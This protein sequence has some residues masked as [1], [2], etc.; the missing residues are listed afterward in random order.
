MAILNLYNTVEFLYF[1]L[2][3][4]TGQLTKGDSAFCACQ[5]LQ[6]VLISDLFENFD[7]TIGFLRLPS[8]LSFLLCW[9]WSHNWNISSL[10]WVQDRWNEDQVLCRSMFLWDRLTFY[11]P[12][13]R[14]YYLSFLLFHH[15]TDVFRL[16]LV[17]GLICSVP[18]LNLHSGKRDMIDV[19]SLFFPATVYMMAGFSAVSTFFPSEGSSHM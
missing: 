4:S 19:R 18:G 11:R 10:Y 7:S 9:P 16:P 1:L 2:G 5:L 6:E 14:S 8:K 13:C 12:F 3:V 17:S 15:N